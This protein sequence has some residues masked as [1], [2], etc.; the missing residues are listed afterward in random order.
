MIFT[1][2]IGPIDST[3]GLLNTGSIEEQTKQT[4]ANLNTTL[5][6]GGADLDDIVQLTV[7]LSDFNDYA[8]FNKSFDEYFLPYVKS[9]PARATIQAAALYGEI[10][11][12]I[13][14]IAII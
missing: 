9:L 7:Y 4:I 5:N 1:A 3:T 8:G 6:A 11:I 14:A 13:V 12:E 2:G 10:K